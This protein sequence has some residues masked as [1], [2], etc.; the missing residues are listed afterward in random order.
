MALSTASESRRAGPQDPMVILL[1]SLRSWKLKYEKAL[2]KD[3]E[4]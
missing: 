1:W 2:I 4:L 3:V